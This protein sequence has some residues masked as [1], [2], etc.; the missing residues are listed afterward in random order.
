MIIEHFKV[1]S[2]LKTLIGSELITDNYVAV[3][4]LVKNSFD[5]HATEVNVV[6]N[7]IYSTDAKIIIQDNGKGMDR[8]DLLNKWLFV[9]KS[10]K[11]DNTE[12]EDYR[13]DIKLSNV[14]AGAKG[15]GRFSC[16][17][18]GK[19]LNLISIKD[20]PNAKIENLFIDWKK[21]EEDQNKEFSTIDIP[22]NVLNN[23]NYDIE[24]GTVLEITGIAEDEWDRESF[25]KLKERLSKL[26]RPDL[27][28]NIAEKDFQVTLKVPE[29]IG[30]D[31]A[32]IR[33]AEKK[34]ENERRGYVYKNTVNGIIKN[35]VFDDL[36][37]RTTKIK[38]SI[39]E[40]GQYVVTQLVDRN[41][42]IYKI[43]EQNQFELLKDVSITLYFLN[44]SAKS[45]F[46]RRMGVTAVEYGN[47]F[48]YKNGFR[49]YPFGER[50]YDSFGV[51]NRAVQGFSRYIGLR[52]LIGQ[53]DIQGENPDLRETTSRDGGLVRTNAYEQ[54]ASREEGGLL[55][56]TLRRLE[57]YVVDVTQWGLNDENFELSDSEEAKENLIKLISNIYD[58]KSLIS[59][60]YNE[61]II[62]L[63]DQR[64]EKSAKKLVKNFKRLAE[65]SDDR[66]L[67]QD[68]KKL[69]KRIDQQTKAIE[70]ASKEIESKAAEN[71]SL[72]Y[73]LEQQVGE[74]LFARAVLGNEAKELIS[75]QHHIFRH[76]AQH[77]TRHI[78]ALINE[79]NNDAPKQT[80][81]DVANK[82][83]FENEKIIT[84]SRFVSKA[85]FD[86]TI[87]KIKQDL[88]KFV[89]EY[90]INVYK[91][92]KR[93]ALNNQDIDIQVKGLNLS[94]VTP[95]KPID[96][97]IA[98]DNLFNNSFK[99]KATTISLQWEAESNSIIRLEVIDNGIGIPEKNLSK[100]FEFRFS[101]TDG[102]G[103]GLYHTQEVIK[104]MGGEISVANNKDKP[105]VTFSIKFKK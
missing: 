59:V 6:F 64:E 86:T 53:I 48:V 73:D 97:I 94:F 46:K 49:I 38:T 96:I 85:N 9:A 36:G 39:S 82:I 15:V 2:G 89:N 7:N 47:I 67:L 8:S 12:D 30:R 14:Y 77:I 104:R 100:V 51:D 99:A 81:L 101:T 93:S 95:F 16:D 22:R 50:G 102:S 13:S 68:A 52:N 11:R 103:L 28:Q 23:I 25:L 43:E 32:V 90:A 19:Y 98:L 91:E 57:R 78:D 70:S 87:S 29:E 20:K 55:F 61:D 27:N 66:Q 105:G 62:S 4:E 79:I 54:L 60:D 18:L 76:S 24:H 72:K 10:A 31:R 41:T 74:T 37:I 84:L 33:E 75:I 44:R 80:L 65:I 45:I 42:F 71:K 56:Q 88:V 69:E 35:F 5:A 63:L 21:F 1:S 3:F 17:R 40:D 58:D 92:Y 83:S 26:I 34:K